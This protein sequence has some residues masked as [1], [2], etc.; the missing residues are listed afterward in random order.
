MLS[1]SAVDGTC[2]ERSTLGCESRSRARKGCAAESRV[3]LRSPGAAWRSRADLGGRSR[4]SARSARRTRLLRDEE[5]AN[6]GV[7]AGASP[8]LVGLVA[9]VY[10][11]LPPP[12][13][14]TTTRRMMMTTTILDRVGIPRRCVVVGALSRSI[15]CPAVG[16]GAK[17]DL[18]CSIA[19]TTII[20]ILSIGHP[21]DMDTP[22]A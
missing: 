11:G 1:L 19:K 8:P 20:V 9:T 2:V 22:L 5:A 12:P 13:P 6:G 18:V 21:T 10:C 4:T 15:V 3:V 17:A 14:P 16:R 7:P